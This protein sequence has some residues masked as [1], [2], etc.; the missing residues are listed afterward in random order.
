[1]LLLAIESYPAKPHLEISGEVLLKTR[2]TSHVEFCYVGGH[3]PWNENQDHFAFRRFFTNMKS[4]LDKFQKILSSHGVRVIEDPILNIEMVIQIEDWAKSFRGDILSLKNFSYKG[5][6]LGLGVASSLISKYRNPHID[7]IK[8]ADE[9]VD[10]LIS[11]AMVYEKS[12][13][14][15][16]SRRP[17][18]VIT[19]N[20][21]LA[22][23]Y[24]IVKAALHAGIKIRLHERGATFKK[25]E[26][27]ESS[28]H[29]LERL[30]ERV[31]SFWNSSRD[32]EY[33]IAQADNFFKS[34]RGGDG[35]GWES[36][37]AKQIRGH[38]IPKY[39][40]RRVVYFS[41]SEDEFAALDDGIV[42]KFSTTGQKGAIERLLKICKKIDLD[43]IIRVHPNTA[44][45][46]QKEQEWWQ[47]L[48]NSGVEVVSPSATIDSYALLDT[49]DIACTY[50]STMGVEAAYWGIPSILL[51]DSGYSGLGCCFEPKDDDELEGLLVDTPD[52][53]NHVGCLQYGYYLST[54]GKEFEYYN[55]KS[56]FE[57][58]FLGNKLPHLNYVGRFLKKLKNL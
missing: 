15:I 53:W 49:A 42:H 22:C 18:V 20:G 29:S 35:I 14:L 37:T 58:S 26:I 36:F 40:R 6:T 25:Y 21:R 12:I 57:G 9:V 19:F 52:Q 3:L 50:G 1:M 23:S 38:V 4:R 30:R 56:L 44:G 28:V 5:Y 16:K 2:A 55:P 33:A 7:T 39:G 46:D 45:A 34:R 54:F 24:P 47:A 41:S 17:D 11:A 31:I 48:A 8:L 13:Q 27:F 10:A 43:L 32:C 51:G